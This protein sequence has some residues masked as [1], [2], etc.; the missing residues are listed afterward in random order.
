MRLA[1]FSSREG[2]HLFT[3]LARIYSW[4]MPEPEARNWPFRLIRRV[5]DLGTLEDIVAMEQVFGRGILV[6]AIT[7]A[8]AGAMRPQSWAFWHYRL[9][10][11]QPGADC[12]PMPARRVA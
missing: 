9:N 3:R 8:E 1:P 11:V 2:D 5:M 10:L 4:D 12:P 6:H 7:T